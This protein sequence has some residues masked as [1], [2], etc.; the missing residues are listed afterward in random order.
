MTGAATAP[1]TIAPADAHELAATLRACAD[2]H[3]AVVAWGGGTLQSLGNAPA[4]CDALLSLE[5]LRGIV[6]Y[7]PRDL[8]AGV[9]AGTTLAEIAR[10]LGEFG[11]QL[12]FDAP[13][14]ARATIG[15]TIAAGW[16]GPRRARYGRP[17]DVLIGST[18]ALTDGTLAHAGGMVVKNVTGYDMS[19][20]YAGSLGTLAV[21]VRANVKAVPRPAARRLAIAPIPPDVRD[22]AIAAVGMLAIEPSAALVI[23]G[24]AHAAPLP[25][26]ALRLV[27]L[28]EGSEAV[29]DR[30]TRD[31]RSVLGAA[32]VAETQLLDGDAAERIFAGVVDAY[33]ETSERSLT[34]RSTGLPS[35]AWSRASVAA[36]LAEPFGLRSETIV[37][38]RNGDVIVRASA[39]RT[40]RF[41]AT[42]VDYDAAV[43][44]AIERTTVLAGAPVLRAAIDA[45]GAVPATIAMMRA[46]KARF[47]PAN[48]LAPGRYVG[49]L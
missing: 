38:L 40:A 43:R 28:F 8:T 10:T 31:L 49:G 2:E 6:D 42:V 35:T 46:L 27:I 3:A 44:G 25:H 37:D 21:I 34:Y 4:R 16:A 30:A 22:R 33:V 36:A 48:V 1:R 23:D 15:G 45:W 11:Q 24:F 14:P 5:H 26:A 19:K 17:R 32:G 41:T 18:V 29:V 13:F 47:D 12:P 20:V 7:E 39:A 9:L